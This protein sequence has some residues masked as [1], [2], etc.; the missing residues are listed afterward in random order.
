MERLST[1]MDLFEYIS[2]FG[3]M[4]EKTARIYFN[5][6]VKNEQSFL[7]TVVVNGYCVSLYECKCCLSR[8][9]DL[10]DFGSGTFCKTKGEKFTGPTSLKILTYCCY[11]AAFIGTPVYSCR[12]IFFI[13]SMI[14]IKQPFGCFIPERRDHYLST[15]ISTAQHILECSFLL[16]LFR[17]CTFFVCKFL[18]LSVR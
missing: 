14:A 5:Q 15:I 7:H 12:N 3:E 17:N 16:H 4:D 2:K 18:N 9:K 1:F 13:T 6:V 8:F 11:K 10:I